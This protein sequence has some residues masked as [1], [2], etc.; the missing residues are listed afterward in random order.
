M[1]EG[2]EAERA[3]PGSCIAHNCE[4]QLLGNSSHLH[5]AICTLLLTALSDFLQNGWK[6]S[7]AN[8]SLVGSL[9][10]RVPRNGIIPT[11]YLTSLHPLSV[12]HP[13]AQKPRGT[14]GACLLPFSNS[15]KS[16]AQTNWVWDEVRL[17]R[18]L[19]KQVKS[20]LQIFKCE[21]PFPQFG[22]RAGC[23]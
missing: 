12:L 23:T 11:D 17:S 13:S 4:G 6:V 10:P 7:F 3:P 16:W 19:E 18:C 1:E 21:P 5:E 14:A 2:V 15:Q 22:F 8:C 9:I 20:E